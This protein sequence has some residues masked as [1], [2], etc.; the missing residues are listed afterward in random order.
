MYY[1]IKRFSILLII[2]MLT[3]SLFA[4]YGDQL[5]N[6]GFEEW[7]NRDSEPVHWHSNGTAT[8]M[9]SGLLPDDQ[10]EQ[11]G[12]ARPG[13]TGSKS[14][15]LIPKSAYG[16]TANGNL[17]NGRMNAG[18]M[19][20]TGS[21]NYNQTK[22]DESAFNMPLSML[23]DSLTIWVCFRSN[24]TSAKA[25]VKAVVHGNAD[26]KIMANGSEDPA[27]M[28]VATAALSFNRTSTSGGSYTWRRL[29]IPFNNNG[30]CTDVRYILMT[31]TT[32]ET[33]GS[34]DTSDDLFIDDALLVYNPTLTMGNLAST[35]FAPG[36]AVTI[37]F[38]LTGT[39]S[40]D[41][42]NATANAVIA[43][44]S[45]ANGSFSNPTELGR[46]TTN[47]SGNITAQI[48]NVANGQY[49]IRV[50]STNYP[51][52]G[53]NAQQVTI[54]V[55]SYTIAVNANPTEGGTVTGG[56]EYT[57]GQSCTV[58]ATANAGYTFTNWTEG[59]NV[60]STNASYTFNVTGNRTLV[61]NFA[62][63]TY[64]I[65]ATADP[66]AGGTVTGAGTY[67]HGAS[68]TLTATANTGYTFV[69]WTK[70]GTQV[71]TNA[72]YT[73]T[74]SEAGSY[75][76]H[77]SLNSYNVTATANPTAGGTV[78]GAGEYNHGASCTLTATANTGYTFTNWTE[79]GSVVSTNANYTFT[80]EGART[81]VANF[82]LNSYTITATANP[83]AGG[84]VSG[85]GE[86]NHGAS[87][88]LTATANTGYTFTNWTEN[89][90]VVSSN[91]NYTFTVTGNRTL[92][93]NFTLN[94]Y[95]VATAANPAAGGTVS[96]D[97]EYNHGESC[98]V[99]A[100]ANTGYTFS[101]WTE[102][103]SVVSTNSSYTF[104]VEGN[105]NLVAN[106]SNITY[107]I[108]VSA[109]PSNSGTATGG[110]TYNHGQSCTVIATSADGYTFTNWTE[111]G[112]V[113]STNANYTFT[114]TGN[115]T[116]VANFEEQAPDTYNI[117]VSPNPNVGGTVTG[118]GNY[119][120]GEQC[121]VTA[122]ANAG[123]TFVEWTENGNQV[124][125]DASYTFTVAG[126]RTLV[127]EFQIQSYT[128]SAA[129]NPS[130]S[131][132]ITGIGDYEYGQSCTLVATANEGYTFTNWT[133]DGNVVSTN[134]NYIFTVSGSRELI[135]NFSTNAYT[136]TATADPMEGG[137]VTG[138][139]N[140]EYGATCTLTA[141]ANYEYIFVKWTKN[142]EDVSTE[143]TFTFTV[144]ASEDY[145]A[146][147]D[148]PD[149]IE[150]VTIECQIFPNPFTSMVSIKAE[151]AL[152][153]VSVYDIYGRLLKE[154]KV[155]DMEIEL[156]MSDLSN[157]A[158]LLK[159][160]YGDSSSVHRIMKVRK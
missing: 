22:R 155:S 62:L 105:R 76:A 10:I 5:I 116:L 86:F 143:A 46:V 65:T 154:Q 134:A 123:Y 148:G 126:N 144:T 99:T 157:G 129:V 95:T 37:P 122:T 150:E 114:V 110:G 66:T 26:Y 89:G 109:N 25:Q 15:R 138:S 156:D 47:T 33:P 49:Q 84:T 23:P 75:V 104:T 133:E 101:N 153:T 40:P 92:V 141:T 93:A 51:M 2:S 80:V 71:S 72:S 43:Q 55:P 19:S 20:A 29:S 107:T 125:T 121:T 36:D 112:S 82:T 54:T 35:S 139:G 24:S 12:H 14:V 147:F 117:N 152:K 113:V 90:S 60:A 53:Q 41:N 45:D 32:N 9:F 85:A 57:S 140:Y 131:G 59:G 3:S 11:S 106:F 88:T 96:G 16:V 79:N 64:S 100:T 52:I 69:N 120:E 81:L 111:N 70:N 39:M 77:F 97:G 74:V 118:G 142:G 119:M 94:T 31:A 98:T 50:I 87:C 38:T 83:T 42:L 17:T 34:G 130:N 68:C 145:V 61:A 149:A 137:T 8:G 63:N 151:K 4:Q 146:H 132:V 6:R 127:A 18:S 102:N 115:R 78:S 21:S 91:A 108:T 28:R 124:S 159:L 136:I 135:A 158:Y 67:N 13:S 48:P 103:G 44:M 30:P 58:T 73:F 128:I 1:F 7:T 27:N 56:G 160:D